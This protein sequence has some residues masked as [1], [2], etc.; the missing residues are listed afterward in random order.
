MTSNLSPAAFYELAED[1]HPPLTE[2]HMQ[3]SSPT[4]ISQPSHSHSTP[5]P[6]ATQVELLL[7][8]PGKGAIPVEALNS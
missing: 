6:Q 2:T 4:T 3:Q 5:S 7:G 8:E 1:S